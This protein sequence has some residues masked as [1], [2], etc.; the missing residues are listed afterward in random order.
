LSEPLA[1]TFL[2]PPIKKIGDLEE[3]KRLEKN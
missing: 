1:F 3:K 2:G